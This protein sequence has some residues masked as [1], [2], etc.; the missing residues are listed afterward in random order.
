MRL[1]VLESK[2]AKRIFSLQTN[3]WKIYQV[4]SIPLTNMNK[5]CSISAEPTSTACWMQIIAAVSIHFYGGWFNKPVLL[6]LILTF[7]CPVLAKSSCF[8]TWTTCNYKFLHIANITDGL[9]HILEHMPKQVRTNTTIFWDLP[10]LYR[11]SCC[12]C[13]FF[14]FFFLKISQKSILVTQY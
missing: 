4:H 11:Y 13:S 1:D 12:G 14:F 7:H 6:S 9:N 5:T 2:Q 8:L 3:W 10:F